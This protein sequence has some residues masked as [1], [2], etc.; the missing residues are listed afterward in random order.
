MSSNPQAGKIRVKAMCLIVHDGKV[1]VADGDTLQSSSPDRRVVPS[2]F[3][4]VLGGSLEF[5]ETVEQGV[6]REIRE[7]L[8][9]EIENLEQ[10]GVVENIFTYAG[11]P[12]HEIVFLYKGD[13]AKRELYEKDRWHVVEDGYEFDAVWV[14]AEQVLNGSK[15]LYPVF[16][17]ATILR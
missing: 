10:L 16:D 6:R 12:G 7:E 3:Y 15:P 9:S 5:Q 8:N 13:L 2:S 4:R 14:P 11:E 1:L 17:Y